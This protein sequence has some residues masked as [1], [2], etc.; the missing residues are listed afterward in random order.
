[1]TSCINP[2]SEQTDG[3][4]L[5]PTVISEKDLIGTWK[6]GVPDHSDTLIIKSDGTYKQI[7]SVV[8]TDGQT[9]DYESD[10]H[11]W[12]IEL[13]NKGITY[14]HLKNYAFCGMNADIS[15]NTRNGG[16]YDFCEDERLIME[17]EGILLVLVTPSGNFIHLHYPLGGENSYAY[18]LLE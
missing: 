1:M 10:W 16:G 2:A 11:N 12:Y 4:L 14:L 18:S 15:C 6:A 8:F 13:S 3:C 17:G 5:V 9:I 7:V